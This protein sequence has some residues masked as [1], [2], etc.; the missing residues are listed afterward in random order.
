[1]VYPLGEGRN[2]R[3]AQRGRVTWKTAWH[4]SATK[5]DTK[6]SS[7]Q[8]FHTQNKHQEHIFG[9]IATD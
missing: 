6:L 3:Q 1:M 4:S 7:G 8:V 5:R 2:P 9:G